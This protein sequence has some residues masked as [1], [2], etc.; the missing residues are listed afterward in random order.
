[1]ADASPRLAR[2]AGVIG[3]ATMTSRVLG[4]VREQVLAFYFGAGDAMDA[5][6]V[7]Y[8]VPNLVRDL[9]AEGAMSAAFVP[10]FAKRLATGSRESSWHLASSV[11]NALLL[12][13]GAIVA[14]GI[15]FT[16]PLLSIVSGDF[17]NVPGKFELTA[18]LTRTM[19]PFLTLVAL[20]AALMGMLNALG[21]FFI[22]ALSPAMFNV[23]TIACALALIPFAPQLGVQPIAIVAIGTL[24]GGLGQL[25]IQLPPLWREGFRYRPILDLKD[26]GLHR[27]L[28]LM[29][30]A[31]IGLAATQI[32]LFVNTMLATALGTGAVSWLNFAF[33]LMY[34]PIGLFGVSIATAATP[35]MARLANAGDYVQMRSTV[36]HA[37]GLMMMLNVPATLGLI[38]LASPIIAL[39]FERGNFTAADT[40]ATAAALRWY[41]VGLLGYSVVRIVSPIFYALGRARVPAT[42]SVVS[43]LLNVLL[44]LLLVR[45]MGY[46]GLALGTSLAALIN[47]ATQLALLRLA[48]GGVEGRR[49]AITFLKIATASIA[50]AA[51]AWSTNSWLSDVLAGSSLAVQT[52]RVAISIAVAAIVLAVASTLLRVREFEEARDMVLG[53]LRRM[54][55]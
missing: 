47:A 42:V 41:A 10:T 48:I 46:T 5:F 29:L 31:T 20:A 25:V 45:V 30:P 3:I 9:F 36:A 16:E 49:V 32:N 55:R 39:I 11:I 14:A 6:N 38:A 50:M 8:R 18:Q 53:K 2:S 7:A 24:V 1:M 27:I 51:A 34:L 40:E 43:V 54:G 26:E 52:A 12:V 21:H 15:I 35:T 4:L 19:M 17:V 37:L 44:N 33:R 22:P 28:L 13:T 23:G